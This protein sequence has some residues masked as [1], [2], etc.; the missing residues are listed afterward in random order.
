MALLNVQNNG[1]APTNAKVG[2]IINTAG[3]K[4]EIVAPN[5]YGA[6]YNPKSGFW[7]VRADV[8]PLVNSANAAISLNNNNLANA[9]YN[10]NV[11]SQ[12]SSAQQYKFNSEEAEKSRKW[13]EMMSNTAHQREVE[14]LIKAGLNPVLSATLGG[15]STPSGATASGSSYSGQKADVDTQFLPLLLSLYETMLNNQTSKE[16]ARINADTSMQTAKINSAASIYTADTNASTKPFK[17]TFGDFLSGNSSRAVNR[18]E[19]LF[20]AWDYYWDNYD[21]DRS[22]LKGWQR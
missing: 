5:T 13:Q 12:N 4:Y 8:S 16:I 21:Y 17:V 19:Q 20:N 2:D 7:S 1:N 10:A 15:S 9:A 22:K 3:G 11:I 18:I 6:S 14:D